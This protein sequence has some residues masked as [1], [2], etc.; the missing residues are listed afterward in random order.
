MQ[1]Y[2]FGCIKRKIYTHNCYFVHFFP[3]EKLSIDF[4]DTHTYIH[5]AS[6]FIVI[7][8]SMERM[9]REDRFLT[10]C[11]VRFAKGSAHRRASADRER[12]EELKH[13]LSSLPQTYLGFLDCRGSA[14]ETFHT[15]EITA[16]RKGKIINLE[17]LPWNSPHSC[18]TTLGS[19]PQSLKL[20]ST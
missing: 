5:F 10:F 7:S 20:T 19:A 8:L 15:Q 2:I 18:R 9:G 13:P 1:T 3:F 16:Y 17:L 6:R 4:M 12:E 14:S 11:I